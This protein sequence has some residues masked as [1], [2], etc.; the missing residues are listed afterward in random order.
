MKLPL[1][2]LLALTVTQAFAAADNSD[3]QEVFALGERKVMVDAASIHTKGELARFWWKQIAEAPSPA[4][5]LNGTNYQYLSTLSEVDCQLKTLR[6][7]QEVRFNRTGPFIYTNL[8][9]V[10]P[11]P[12]IPEGDALAEALAG[13]VCTHLPPIAG[14]A[15]PPSGETAPTP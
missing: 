3:W 9:I 15:P 5:A 14:E 13:F 12:P 1:L 11:M 10:D 7:R 6:N 4:L 8:D 2:A